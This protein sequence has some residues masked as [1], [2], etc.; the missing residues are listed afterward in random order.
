MRPTLLIFLLISW[1]TACAPHVVYRP[2]ALDLPERPVLAPVLP[3][4]L[5]CLS[6]ATYSAIVYR[7]RMLKDHIRVLE[8]TIQ[9]THTLKKMG[10]RK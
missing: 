10:K 6:D 2:I 7:E 5:A 1:L 3:A 8:A 4:D 9:S